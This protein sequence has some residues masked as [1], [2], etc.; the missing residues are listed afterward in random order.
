MLR[1]LSEVDISGIRRLWHHISPNIPPMNDDKT[2]VAIH[3]ARTQTASLPISSRAFSHRWLCDNGFQSYLPD[4][5]KPKAERLYPKIVTSVGISVNFKS[6]ILKPAAK[7][8]ERAMCDA[9]ED[10]YAEKKT[11][12]DYLR[13]VMSDARDRATIKLFGKR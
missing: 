11:D 4:D 7:I 12:A 1:C 6:A 9:V 2:F 10:A 13:R 5:L 3:M 8:I